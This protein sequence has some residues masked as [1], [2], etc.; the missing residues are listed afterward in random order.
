VKAGGKSIPGQKREAPAATNVIDLVS[1]LQKSLSQS[2]AGK[3]RA[4]KSAPAAKPAA[5]AKAAGG[6]ARA[7]KRRAHEHAA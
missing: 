2:M 5:P 1:V 7:S 4:A 3:P 6:K